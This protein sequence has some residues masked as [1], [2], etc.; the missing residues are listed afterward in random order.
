MTLS[1]RVTRLELPFLYRVKLKLTRINFQDSNPSK[2][3]LRFA[4]GGHVVVWSTTLASSDKRRGMCFWWCGSHASF[5]II[6]CLFQVMVDPPDNEEWITLSTYDLQLATKTFLVDIFQQWMALRENNH[7]LVGNTY[8]KTT[9]LVWHTRVVVLCYWPLS[10]HH[11]TKSNSFEVITPQISGNAI[12]R[13]SLFSYFWF[14]KNRKE[15][16]TWSA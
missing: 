6:I 15:K 13:R 9:C 10:P 3:F 1:G 5:N 11:P 16:R 2:A 12:P 4:H 8:Y 14:L 7:L